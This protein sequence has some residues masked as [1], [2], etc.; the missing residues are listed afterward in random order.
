MKLYEAPIHTRVKLSTGQEVDFH[1]IDGMYSC[2]TDEEGNVVH[3]AA[4]T[5]VEVVDK[6]K[7]GDS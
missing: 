5:E 1:H 7:L 6:E 2:C 4:W 3:L